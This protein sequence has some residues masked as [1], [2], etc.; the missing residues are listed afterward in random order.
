MAYFTTS[1]YC[2]KLL[3]YTALKKLYKNVSAIIGAMAGD[4]VKDVSSFRVAKNDFFC[5]LNIF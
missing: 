5:K 3:N 1:P 2:L 4:D